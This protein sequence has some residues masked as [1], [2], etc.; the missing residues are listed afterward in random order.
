MDP[1]TTDFDCFGTRGPTTSFH[2]LRSHA[3]VI[4]F[5]TSSQSSALLD[6][7]DELGSGDLAGLITG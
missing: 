4:Q 1:R 6:L 2:L 7:V 5:D 3:G